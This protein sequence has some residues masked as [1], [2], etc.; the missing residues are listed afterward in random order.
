VKLKALAINATLKRGTASSSTDAMIRTMGG[1]FRKHAVEIVETVRLANFDILPGV[2]SDEGV[3]DDWPGIRRK[4]IEADIL[5][6][7]TPIWMG[8]MSSIAKRV[9]E[10]FDAFLDETDD[11]GRMP[12]YSKVAVAAIVGN[13]DGAHAVS[14]NLFQALNDVGFTIP[15]VAAYYWVGEAMGST[16]YR[17]LRTPRPTVEKTAK[18]VA[19]NAAHLAGLLKQAPYPG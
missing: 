4:V 15:A 5:I 6:F 11:R 17:D 8:Q 1:A 14:A 16:D 9:L 10:R 2:T 13:E 3:G 12:S 7:G 19:A 18:M